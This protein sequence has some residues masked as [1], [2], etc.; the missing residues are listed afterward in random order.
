MLVAYFV[1]AVGDDQQQRHRLDTPRQEPQKIQ[2][3]SIGPVRILNDAHPCAALEGRNEARVN[4]FVVTG[5]DRCS[6]D[7]RHLCR[8]TDQH[9][10]ERTERTRSCQWIA[11]SPQ[12]LRALINLR[13]ESRDHG[14]FAGSGL[15]AQ[16]HNAP[17]TVDDVP[18][19]AVELG[20]NRIAL[21]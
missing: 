6:Q 18:P 4:L 14:A 9:V 12:H 21:Q 3:C 2:R 7:G 17:V 19:K 1:I 11:P 16:Q 15:T 8:Q 10:E 13:E 5:V 20:Q